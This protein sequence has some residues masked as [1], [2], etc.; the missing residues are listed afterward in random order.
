MNNIIKAGA[1]LVIVASAFMLIGNLVFLIFG[2]FMFFS[3]AEGIV[4]FFR[5]N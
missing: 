4:I 1:I 2:G 3:I 5:V